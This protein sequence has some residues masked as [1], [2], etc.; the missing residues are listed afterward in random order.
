MKNTHTQKI[1]KIKVIKT[2]PR[3]STSW[4][5]EQRERAK[6]KELERESTRKRERGREGHAPTHEKSNT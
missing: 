5:K 1:F 2:I 6:E 3:K 4:R